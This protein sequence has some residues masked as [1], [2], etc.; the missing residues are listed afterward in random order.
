MARILTAQML[1]NYIDS[2]Q[3]MGRTEFIRRFSIFRFSYSL[4]GILCMHLIT[5][6]R[7]RFVSTIGLSAVL[8]CAHQ[9]PKTQTIN[10]EMLM[11]KNT[12]TIYGNHFASLKT[13]EFIRKIAIIYDSCCVLLYVMFYFGRI[14]FVFTA[15]TATSCIVQSNHAKGKR[16]SKK[17]MEGMELFGMREQTK[18]F[19]RE[20]KQTAMH[21]W[22]T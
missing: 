14:S 18:T 19:A 10:S 6:V 16:E 9:Q 3:V 12:S 7:W 5:V 17:G 21:R 20:Y 1:E 2:S 8:C 4:D 13:S 15:C 11:L 22:S